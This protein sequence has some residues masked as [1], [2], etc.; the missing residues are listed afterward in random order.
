LLVVQAGGE[1]ERPSKILRLRNDL[2]ADRAEAFLQLSNR[3][4][5]Q[6]VFHPG[7][8]T[9]R[10]LYAFTH[11]SSAEF[12]KTNR[13][14]RFTVE[15]EPTVRCDPLSE[16]VIIEWASEGHD[17]GGI[18]FGHDGMLYITSGDG[19]SDSDGWVTGQDLSELL[20]G[21]LRIDVDHPSGAQ[22]YSVPKDNPFVGMTNARPE[23]WAY[24]LRNPWRLCID[25]KTGQIWAATTARTSGKRPTSS[26]AVRIMEWS[27]Y[28]GSHPF[29]LN[30]KLG[31][32]P[33]VAPTIEHSHSEA[34]SLTGGVVYYGD[35]FS[36]LNGAY[37]Y[38]DYSTGTIGAPATTGRVWSGIK[39]WPTRNCR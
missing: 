26:G 28:E 32:T 17:G 12:A 13:I 23:N 21:M 33:A 2:S 20:G 10:H 15:R 25:Q 34:R 24:G 38:G 4:N 36:E 6:C 18:V 27:V 8:R 30:R 5:L 9:N 39:N 11:G 3:L 14:S 7:F 16:R 19:T 37:I 31:P 35:K 29:Y 1:K 22:A